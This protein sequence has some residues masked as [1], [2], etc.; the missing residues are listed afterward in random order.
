MNKKI[1]VAFDLDGVLVDKPPFIPRSII[2]WLFRGHKS[3]KLFYRF[4]TKRIEQLIRKASHFYLLR[5]PIKD[6]VE[7]V[8]KLAKSNQ[9]ELYIISGRYSFL[10]RETEEWLKKRKI[11]DCFSQIFINLNN[12]QPHLF[13]EKILNQIKPDIFVDDDFLLVEYL[14]GKVT[15]DK[16]FCY[17]R[18]SK[19]E[20]DDIVGSISSI[21][22]YL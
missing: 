2:E 14:K 13:K 4:P 7:F 18:S 9:Y 1:K 15:L 21:K 17:S 5:P 10:K 3:R 8:Q 12:E 16:I 11:K 6:N 19:F 22:S 20:K